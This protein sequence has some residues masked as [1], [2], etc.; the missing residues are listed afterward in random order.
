MRGGG[1]RAKAGQGGEGGQGVAARGVSAKLRETRAEPLSLGG[2]GPVP[3]PPR[4]GS[5]RGGFVPFSAARGPRTITFAPHI[6]K[7]KYLSRN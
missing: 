5:A 2:G 6:V 3:P 7:L 1:G 4:F